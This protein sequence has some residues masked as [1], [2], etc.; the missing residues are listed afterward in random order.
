MAERAH[1]RYHTLLTHNH[2]AHTYIQCPIGVYW[3][4]VYRLVCA[5]HWFH[6][7]RLESIF[8]FILSMHREV[9][10]WSRWHNN[11]RRSPLETSRCE[12]RWSAP[13]IYRLESHRS[14][15][16]ARGKSIHMVCA[17]AN[18]NSAYDSEQSHRK[19]LTRSGLCVYHWT[20]VHVRRC[21]LLLFKLINANS[22]MNGRTSV[23]IFIRFGA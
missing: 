14:A 17:L 8:I 23:Y 13:L 10:S 11:I 6:E 12:I 7:F 2:I 16:D 18:W 21:K 20:C 3:P 15:C 5:R 19:I 9:V 1:A 4:I 22:A